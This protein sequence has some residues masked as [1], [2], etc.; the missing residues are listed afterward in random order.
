[1]RGHA[2]FL[3]LLI[4][5]PL[6]ACAPKRE[7]TAPVAL[8]LDCNVAFDAQSA[9]LTAQPHLVPAPHAPGEP[10]AFYST[11]DGRASYLITLKGAPGHP[12]ILMQTASGGQVKTTGC[13]YGDPKGYKQLMAY[14]DGLKTWTR[15]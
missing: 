1:V 11:E 3:P 12:A 15:R 14:L 4:A 7:A 2:E 6:C 13:R 5:L 10:Y 8:A 9:K